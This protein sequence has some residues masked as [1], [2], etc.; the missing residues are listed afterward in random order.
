MTEDQIEEALVHERLLDSEIAYHPSQRITLEELEAFKLSDQKTI[1]HVQGEEWNAIVEREILSH[2]ALAIAET[3]FRELVDDYNKREAQFV[4]QGLSMVNEPV[5]PEYMGFSSGKAGEGGV[6]YAKGDYILASRNGEWH[7]HGE[8]ANPVRL[9]FDNQ[10]Q[11]MAALKAM[12]V[13]MDIDEI[14]NGNK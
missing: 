3:K 10:Y 9:K 8:Y 7:L 4:D 14:L 11:A 13:P 2:Q 6:V 12:G 5:I 1:K